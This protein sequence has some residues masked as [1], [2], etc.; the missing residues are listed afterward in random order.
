MRRLPGADEAG[1][2]WGVTAGSGAHGPDPLALGAVVEA[3][4]RI[5]PVRGVLQPGE[6]CH[7]ARTVPG[8]ASVLFCTSVLCGS[9]LCVDT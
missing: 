5:Q 6:R 7:R 8:P 9:A 3:I 2:P 1:T 4:F